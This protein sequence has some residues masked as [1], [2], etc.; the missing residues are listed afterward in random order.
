MIEV[1]GVPQQQPADESL[2]RVI[3]LGP[4]HQLRVVGHHAVGDT[5]IGLAACA[6][7]IKLTNARYASGESNRVTPAW[8][9][10]VTW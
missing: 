4:E 10:L 7:A 8:E 1:L 2:D 5:R 9:R 3:R 6:S